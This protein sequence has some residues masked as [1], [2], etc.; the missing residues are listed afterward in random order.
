MDNNNFVNIGIV[1]RL[2]ETLNTNQC[3]VEDYHDGDGGGAVAF[4]VRVCLP[5]SPHSEKEYKTVTVQ[6]HLREE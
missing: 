4:E 6:I 1:S 2:Y 3:T 5:G